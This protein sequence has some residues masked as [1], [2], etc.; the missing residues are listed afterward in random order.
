LVHIAAF[1]PRRVALFELPAAFVVDNFVGFVGY[2]GES[3]DALD[4]QREFA[5]L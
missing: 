5:F 2:L 4:R 1:R 3:R